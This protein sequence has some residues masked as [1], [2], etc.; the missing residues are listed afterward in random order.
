MIKKMKFLAA[1]F[2]MIWVAVAN[3]QVTTS[4]MSGRVT[5]N[6]KEPLIGATIVAIHTPTGTVYGASTRNDGSYNISNMRIGG[7]YTIEVS[8]IG[9]NTEK[10]AD[11]HLSLGE[12]FVLNPV[13]KEDTQLLDEVVVVGDGNTSVFSSNRTG[14]QEIITREKMDRLPTVTRSLNDFTKLTPMSSGSNFGGASYRFNNVTVDGAS[15]NNSF[16]LS[17]SLGASG[18]EPISLEALEQVQVMIA[19]Y[20]VRNGGFTGAGINSVTKSGTNDFRASAY[21]YI[22]SP[23]LI[24]YRVKD[25]IISVS[26]FSNKQYGIS[27][28]GP[29][30]KNKLFFYLN[31]ELDRQET[32]ITYTTENSAV[33]AA[34]LQDISNF[35]NAQFGYT[36]GSFNLTKQNT[37]ADRLT[38]R[39]DWNVNRNGVLIGATSVER[40]SRSTGAIG[41]E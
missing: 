4:S 39:L 15:F 13:L 11:I 23:D 6:L 31:G 26:D 40:S 29:I 27:L 32:P 9:Y 38:L 5:D 16:G 10:L 37:Q 34:V 2:M 41:V 35:L 14:A 1:A 17:S 18:T 8:Y 7:P 25:N 20:D 19:P 24:G 30:V 33:D 28:S 12:D 21:M 3:A 36:P 22:K